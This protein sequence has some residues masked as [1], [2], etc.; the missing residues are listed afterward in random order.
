[1]ILF[2]WPGIASAQTLADNVP[3]GAALQ[4]LDPSLHLDPS[5]DAS[6]R[7]SYAAL[8]GETPLQSL[9]RAAGLMVED[10]IVKIAHPTASSRGVTSYPDCS[11]NRPTTE[12]FRVHKGETW[13]DVIRAWS[14]RAHWQPPQIE[15]G[16]VFRITTD[17]EFSGPFACAAHE[18]LAYYEDG[19]PPIRHRIYLRNNS[20][21]IW[22]PVEGDLQETPCQ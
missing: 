22:S 13:T 2:A 7:V 18:F 5:L 20:I 11:P 17:A 1:L 21:C 19:D 16:A 9:L 12:V 15:T 3:L 10:G 14:D 4:L 8:P 6:R